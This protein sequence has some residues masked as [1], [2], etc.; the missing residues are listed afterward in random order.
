MI[1][2]VVAFFFVRSFVCAN[3]YFFFPFGPTAIGPVAFGWPNG[4][5]Q[6][7]SEQL[8]ASTTQSRSVF[9]ER[10]KKRRRPGRTLLKPG[11]MGMVMSSAPLSE[12]GYKIKANRSTVG[13]R[14]ITPRK[15][16]FFSCFHYPLFVGIV[17]GKLLAHAK[18]Q[19]HYI[20]CPVVVFLHAHYGGFALV[21]SAKLS[22]F[23]RLLS[24]DPVLHGSRVDRQE[25]GLGFAVQW[26][27]FCAFLLFAG[28]N[29][30]T[31]KHSRMCALLRVT[32]HKGNTGTYGRSGHHCPHS[33]FML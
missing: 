3:Y 27:Q 9:Q 29:L 16:H 14:K 33:L 6:E 32:S 15:V 31:R 11:T 4:Y 19:T 18:C 23:P 22:L 8:R 13:D 10:G 21:L 1:G 25:L 7:V 12:R 17:L 24:P 20:L 28:G 2:V 26:V 30:A 5:G